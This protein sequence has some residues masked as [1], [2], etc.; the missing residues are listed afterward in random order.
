MKPVLVLQHLSGDGP[1]YLA[2]WL[3]REG[4]AFEVFNTEA[5]DAFPTRIDGY[6]ALAVLG[7][8]MSANDDL[9]SLRVAE[10]L[11]REAIAQRVPVVGHCLG[12]Q[13]MA[14]ALGASVQVMPAPEVGWHPL[15][16]ADPAASAEWFGSEPL[17]PVFQW[18]F[19]SFSLPPGAIWLARS[20]ACANQAFAFDG[21][22]LAM[23]FHIEVDREKLMRWSSSSDPGYLALPV[24]S[25]TVQ[26]G[27]AMRERAT[28][29]LP[30][31][32]ALA[33]RVYARWLR[34]AR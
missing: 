32:H 12:G 18:H 4:R 2:T 21:L 14:R 22:H 34:A 33:D 26:T 1:A 30:A 5:G 28:L 16:P 3:R 23:Q 8:E 19:E 7:G 29:A 13:L 27:P 20:D 6:G 11:I 10:T 25:A 31:Q 9:P 24:N 17:P 15:A